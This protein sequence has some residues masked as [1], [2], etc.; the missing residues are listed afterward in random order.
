[1]SSMIVFFYH[2][3]TCQYQWSC[4]RENGRLYIPSERGET[5]EVADT[6]GSSI[7]IFRTPNLDSN[8]YG[9]VTVIE[10][11]YRYNGH[12]DQ[13]IQ[14]NWTVLILEDEGDNFVINRTYYIQSLGSMGGA[15]CTSGIPRPGQTTCCDKTYINGFNLLTNFIFGVTESAHGNTPGP[16]TLLL[17]YSNSQTRYWVDTIQ[18]VKAGLTLSEGSTIPSRLSPGTIQRG[19]RMLWFVVGKHLLK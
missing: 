11:C 5:T 14:F 13:V 19:V 12:S 9:L 18:I 15:N 4:T 17:G 2:A 1:M 6:I 10:Y 8:C 7:Y 16:T 3:A